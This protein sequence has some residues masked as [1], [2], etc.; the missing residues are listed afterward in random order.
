MLKIH[1]SS[2]PDRSR[3][4]RSKTNSPTI[5]Y[6]QCLVAIECLSAQE[7]TSKAYWVIEPT[8][9]TG[10]VQGMALVYDSV[11]V[12][13]SDSL[14]FFCTKHAEIE[15]HRK[16]KVF[17]GPT[18]VVEFLRLLTRTWGMDA[19]VRSMASAMLQQMG[20]MSA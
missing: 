17:M 15:I 14:F 18:G 13:V 8:R 10:G 6:P 4:T 19:Y 1:V 2:S 5:T 16:A 7:T 3:T 12:K 9:E 20:H 11:R